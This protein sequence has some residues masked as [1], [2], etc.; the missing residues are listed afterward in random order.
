MSFCLL[1]P[2]IL[3]NIFK[4]LD[5]QDLLKLSQTSKN[6]YYLIN[7]ELEN[8]NIE[9]DLEVNPFQDYKSILERFWNVKNLTLSY[10]EDIQ[11]R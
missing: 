6:F 7:G 9:I 10:F 3:L 8:G 5:I 2:E 11:G 1:P 4:F